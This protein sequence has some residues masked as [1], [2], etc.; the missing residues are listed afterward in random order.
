M[1]FDNR[2]NFIYSIG[3]FDCRL[4]RRNFT[5]VLQ[6]YSKLFSKITV[7]TEITIVLLKYVISLSSSETMRIKPNW[8]HQLTG[9]NLLFLH[10][11]LNCKNIR[12]IPWVQ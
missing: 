2:H 3:K 10:S 9:P 4:H 7:R 11:K 6:G 1:K 5:I 8:M 12:T